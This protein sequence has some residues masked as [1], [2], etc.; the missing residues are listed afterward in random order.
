V[1][2]LGSWQA[3]AAA[4]REAFGWPVLYDCMDNW[5]T[6]PAVRERPEVLAGERELVATAD[7]MTVSGR[8]IQQH[9]ARER[10]DAVLARNAADFA[11]FH[12][13]AETPGAA[14]P[15]PPEPIAGITGPVAGFIGAVLSWFDV[16]LL[17][18]VA[19]ARP[20]VAFVLVGN[21]GRAPRQALESVANVHLLGAQPYEDMP[22]YLRAFDVCLVPFLANRV[23]ESMDLVKVYEYLAQGKPVVTT[24]VAEM[25]RYRRYLYVA[26]GAEEFVAALDRALAEDDPEAVAGRVALARANSWDERVDALEREILPAVTGERT[27]P[28]APAQPAEPKRSASTELA[29][30]RAEAKAAQARLDKLNRSR[31][32]RAARCYWAARKAVE[33]TARRV[34][35]ARGR[36]RGR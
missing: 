20:E 29:A 18:R 23:T 7:A 31:A 33:R 12:D 30:A 22:G 32:V 13:A 27:P 35:E 3:I 28:P 21:V 5:S 16:D 24:P 6:F 1:V 19:S 17:R 8:A 4:A 14:A 25:L 34:G 10:P 15:E 9:W 2:E 11:F 36:S 26:G